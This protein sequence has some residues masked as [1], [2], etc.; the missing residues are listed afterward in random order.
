MLTYDLLSRLVT[1]A[2]QNALLT[3]I[4][5]HSRVSIPPSRAY[6]A[7]S[8]VLLNELIKAV[9]S[10]AIAFAQT[11]DRAS[12]YD[13]TEHRQAVLGDHTIRRLLRRVS[14]KFRLLGKEVFSPDCW[15]LAI[16]ASLY[17]ETHS[18]QDSICDSWVPLPV[19]IQNNL[20]YVAA[21]NLDAATFQVTYQLKILSTA[22]FSVMLLRRRLSPSKWLAL[23]LLA[24]GVAIVQIQSSSGSKAMIPNATKPLESVDVHKMDPFI[25]FMS[26]LAACFTSGFAGVYFEMVLKNRGSQSDNDLWIKNV[27]LSFFSLLPALVPVIFSSSS[28][29]EC[30]IGFDRLP[31]LLKNFGVWAWA[32]VAVQVFGGLVT[33]IVV[34]YADN[35][36]KG[37]ATSLSIVI[38][39]IASMV[40][41]DFH[42]TSSFVLGAA[43]VFLSTW[44]YNRPEGNDTSSQRQ[45]V[46]FELPTIMSRRASTSD[47]SLD[48]PT[49]LSFSSRDDGTDDE[50]FTL[51]DRPMGSPSDPPPSH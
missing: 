3:I 20:Q 19:V 48:T 30:A 7:A 49:S 39:F 13:E 5:H 11:D 25:G 34:K 28:N 33:A 24:I 22:A 51:V 42:A 1:L 16:P 27:Q 43:V 26:V 44:L 31:C 12:S 21:S 46:L 17:G 18:L 32:T 6:S 8:A 4:M 40:L 37:F 10:L 29:P 45:T 9:I 2:I 23:L 14:R 15:K 35:I 50:T 38:S 36:L 41:F 47:P